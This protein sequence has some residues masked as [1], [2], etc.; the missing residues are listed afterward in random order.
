[1]QNAHTA[2]F[3]PTPSGKRWAAD[4]LDLVPS[5]SPKR[6]KLVSKAISDDLGSDQAEKDFGGTISQQ[7]V[8]SRPKSFSVGGLSPRDDP[9]ALPLSSPRPSPNP[10]KRGRSSINVTSLVDPQVDEELIILSKTA[11]EPFDV[12]SV[13]NEKC[14]SNSRTRHEADVLLDGTAKQGLVKAP[15]IA[16]RESGV[17]KDAC[18]YRSHVSRPNSPIDTSTTQHIGTNSRS[19]RAVNPQTV[20]RIHRDD[21]P[22]ELNSDDIALG[23]P[24]EQYKP[25]PTRT[26]STRTS[27][28]NHEFPPFPLERKKRTARQK[29]SRTTDCNGLTESTILL[30][31]GFSNSQA[32][33]ALEIAG[34]DVQVALESLLESRQELATIEKPDTRPV[35]VRS[36]NRTPQASAMKDKSY[37]VVQ[38]TEL[39]ANPESTGKKIQ[40][41]KSDA[42]IM[43]NMVEEQKM[44][45]KPPLKSRVRPKQLQAASSETI[46]VE[47]SPQE[48]F[49]RLKEQVLPPVEEQMQPPVE[50]QKPTPVCE[51][52]IPLKKARGRP[53]KSAKM[54]EETAQAPEHLAIAAVELHGPEKSSELSVTTTKHESWDAMQ[55]YD[56]ALSGEDPG[57]EAQKHALDVTRSS[58]QTLE[59][60]GKSSKTNKHSPI[61]QGKVPYKLGLSR[62]TRVEPLLRRTKK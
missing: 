6:R 13:G 38:L 39:H 51:P 57:G 33:K 24:A 2:L 37:N 21:F 55:M 41:G 43:T 58:S 1:M 11:T 52:S 30:E 59:K 61:G 44:T 15:T 35:S 56:K 20:P 42:S 26:R 9:W 18:V 19:L 40:I 36:D 8:S 60:E 14:R 48:S 62:R 3:E 50:E 22:D 53:K 23:L 17:Q 7:T 28:E 4:D 46:V 27:T 45:M 10:A 5:L 25:R 34:G 54:A 32:G 29:R 31:M 47:Q 12:H 16:K 49:V